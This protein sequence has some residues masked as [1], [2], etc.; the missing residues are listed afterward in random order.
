[1]KKLFLFICM[2]VMLF[3]LVA[4][5]GGTENVATE[6]PVAE[7]AV[8]ENENNAVMQAKVDEVEALSQEL[9]SWYEDNGYLEGETAS[10]VQPVVDKVRTNTEDIIAL[11]KK[12]IDDGGYEDEDVVRI[13]VPID[14]LIAK[15]KKAIEEQKVFEESTKAG[16]GIAVLR[17]KGSQFIAI[18]NETSTTALANGWG[19]DEELNSELNSVFEFLEIVK[20][21]LENPDTMD[22]EY[23]NTI[24]ASIDEMIPVWQDYLTKVSEPYVK[25]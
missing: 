19:D 10:Q 7:K 18:V 22:E 3:T 16:T 21:D 23:I 25:K 11:H 20:G 15:S 2:L 5:G 9:I 13:S 24:I 17:E 4:C 8:I 12:Q 14:E 6:E 1:M